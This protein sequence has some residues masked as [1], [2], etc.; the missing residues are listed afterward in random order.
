M[1]SPVKP[2]AVLFDLDGTF[3]DTAPDMAAALN[4][5][6]AQHHLPPLP[7]ATIRPHVSGGAR[8]MVAVGFGLTPDDAD[9][10]ARRDAFLVE[11]EQHLCVATT[12]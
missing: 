11:Y 7:L 10:I 1:N 12:L 9:F 4:R 8:G 3:A 5:V 2:R 6:R